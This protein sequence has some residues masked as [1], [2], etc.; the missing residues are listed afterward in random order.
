MSRV[1]TGVRIEKSLLKVLK[2]LAEYEETS[3]GD[4]LE[5]IVLSSFA[6]ERRFDRATLG[7][8]VE[9]GRIYGRDLEITDEPGEAAAA[10]ALNPPEVEQDSSLSGALDGLSRMLGEGE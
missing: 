3:L 10:S 4:L 5:G 6:G 2:A 9:L 7:K 8:I 1:Q